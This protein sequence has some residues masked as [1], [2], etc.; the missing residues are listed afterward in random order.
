MRLI[1]DAK[2]WTCHAAFGSGEGE[3][4]DKK[5]GSPLEG[6]AAAQTRSPLQNEDVSRHIADPSKHPLLLYY[7][8]YAWY[9][10]FPGPGRTVINFLYPEKALPTS[11]ETL[12]GI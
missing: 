6:A 7:G 2:G 1:S 10:R 12:E 9:T 5:R 8:R 11:T 3:N 4:G